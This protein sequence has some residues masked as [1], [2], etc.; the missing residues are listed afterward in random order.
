[1]WPVAFAAGSAEIKGQ[2]EFVAAEQAAGYPGAETEGRWYFG[3]YEGGPRIHINKRG[4]GERVIRGGNSTV[5]PQTETDRTVLR[6]RHGVGCRVDSDKS[7]RDVR[8]TMDI[9]PV[10]LEFV[11]IERCPV[12]DGQIQG[13][14]LARRCISLELRK[15]FRRGVPGVIR[16]G[17]KGV[18]MDRC[19][20]HR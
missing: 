17:T 5:E 11:V 1:M 16:S 15:R 4:I 20:H 8:R 14:L 13:I 12:A 10:R 7:R 9:S 3:K 2:A 18:G 19:T 6:S